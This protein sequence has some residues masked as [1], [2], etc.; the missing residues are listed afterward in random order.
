[1]VRKI[2]DGTRYVT[3]SE[4]RIV[5]EFTTSYGRKFYEAEFNRAFVLM[6]YFGYLRREPDREGYEF[7]LAK[8]N[9]FGNFIDAEMVRSFILAPEYRSRFGRP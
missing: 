9:R 3:N 4:G 5:Q 2:V 8:L 1:V 6:Q 7:W